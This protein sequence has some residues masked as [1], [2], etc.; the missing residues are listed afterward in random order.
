MAKGANLATD[1]TTLRERIDGLLA[2]GGTAL[3]DAIGAAYDQAGEGSS[4]DRIE[5][6]VVL[7]DGDDRNS[8][9]QLQALLERIGS[10]GKP[11]VARVFT[12]AYGR[13]AQSEILQRIADATQ[14]KFYAGKPEDIREMFKEISTFF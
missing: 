8:K 12:I 13:D 5:A 6:I 10:H 1:R 9:I 4:H 3:Y 7:S 11:A 2:E 14:A